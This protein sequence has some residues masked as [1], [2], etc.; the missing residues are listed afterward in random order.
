MNKQKTQQNNTKDEHDLEQAKKDQTVTL[1][2]AE[3]QPLT[4]PDENPIEAD[5]AER[6]ASE[7]MIGVAGLAVLVGQ[8]VVYFNER[9]ESDDVDVVSFS[10]HHLFCRVDTLYRTALPDLLATRIEADTEQHAVSS[11]QSNYQLWLKLRAIKS[12]LNQIEP[13]CHL[14]NTVTERMLD[15]LDMTSIIAESENT[16][17]RLSKP[18]MSSEWLQTLNQERWDHA[19]SAL[20]ESLSLWQ[21]NYSQL[22]PFVEHFSQIVTRIPTLERLDETFSIILDCAGAIFGDIVPGFQA[23]SANDDEA[24]CTLLFDLMQQSDQL[25]M[26][27]DRLV[28]PLQSLIEHFAL[29]NVRS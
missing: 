14:L 13:L 21:E 7:R 29:G 26:Q 10:L 16:L 9:A 11:I 28:E 19:L 25:Q 6:P 15:A 18:G 20:T 8:I 24:V 4:T 5:E 27:L 1:Y 23:I 3:D 2:V 17:P 22:V 12:A